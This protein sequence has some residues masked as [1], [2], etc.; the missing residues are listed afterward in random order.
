MSFWIMVFP[1]TGIAGHMVFLFG[2]LRKLHTVLHNGWINL[3]SHQQCKRIPL[4]P[5]FL[6]HLRFVDLNFYL[7]IS[8]IFVFSCTGSSFPCRFFSSCSKNGRLSSCSM[9][10]SHC[11]GFSYCQVRALGP[12]GFVVAAP[13]LWGS[14]VVVHELPCSVACGSFPDQGL[15]LCLLLWQ[16]ILYHWTT[17]EALLIALMMAILIC[18]SWYIIVVWFAFLWLLVRLSIFSHVCWPLYVFFGKMSI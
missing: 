13:G 15:N 6:Q 14:V 8:F 3:Y 18:V 12:V 9:Q 10:A 1:G 5:C 4:F 11:S 16:W 7:F 17:R 2:F